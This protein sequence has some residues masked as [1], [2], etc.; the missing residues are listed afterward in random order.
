MSIPFQCSHCHVKLKLPD[1]FRGQ[2]VRCPQCGEGTALPHSESKP[3]I[4]FIESEVAATPS[5]LA[6]NSS[7][8]SDIPVAE[9]VAPEQANSGSRQPTA[10]GGPESPRAAE[11]PPR[12]WIRRMFARTPR[13]AQHPMAVGIGWRFDGSWRID[14]AHQPWCFQQSGIRGNRAGR[15]Q[16]GNSPERLFRNQADALPTGGSRPHLS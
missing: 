10:S 1:G 3:E 12:E 8:A 9:S 4:Q 14:L 2:N 16:F 11:T 5:F 13:P 15:R 6:G 7:N